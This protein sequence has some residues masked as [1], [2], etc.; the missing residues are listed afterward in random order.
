MI[1]TSA[2]MALFTAVP[3][4]PEE[5]ST[6]S[7]AGD[8]FSRKSTAPSAPRSGSLRATFLISETASLIRV[9]AGRDFHPNARR[10]KRARNV[11]LCAGALAIQSSVSSC[12]S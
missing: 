6:C 7:I 1:S 3:I 2:A 10:R 12:G 9:I 5:L 11:H 4:A 8:T